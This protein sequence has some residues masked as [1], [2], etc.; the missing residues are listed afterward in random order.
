[1]SLNGALCLAA[2]AVAWAVVGGY[3][4]VVV[5]GDDGWLQGAARIVV[6]CMSQITLIPAPPCH[7]SLPPPFLPCAGSVLACAPHSDADPLHTLPTATPLRLPPSSSALALACAVF[8]SV[9]PPHFFPLV[10]RVHWHMTCPSMFCRQSHILWSSRVVQPDLCECTPPLACHCLPPHAPFH[11]QPPSDSACHSSVCIYTSALTGAPVMRYALSAGLVQDP[12]RG[13]GS[14]GGWTP[15]VK[16]NTVCSSMTEGACGNVP[17][18]HGLG[19]QTGE[20]ALPLQISNGSNIQTSS[21]NRRF[22]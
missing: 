7:S 8:P 3:P 5:S 1:M 20:A 17:T 11:T 12:T 10:Y 15:C 6:C 22:A 2:V 19:W 14:F 18:Q 16:G 4:Y 9:H 13:N 21:G